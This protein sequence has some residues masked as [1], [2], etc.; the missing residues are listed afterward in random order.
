MNK[1]KKPHIGF[2]FMALAFVLT[3][4]AFSMS[5]VVY[6]IFGY[7]VN[8]WGVFLAVAAFW[9]TGFLL[10]N[11]LFAGERP[12]WVSLLYVG[13]CVALTFA[14]IL[15]IQPC[16]APMGIY[17]TV[18]NMGDVEA[19]AAGVPRAIVTVVLYVVALLCMVVA[20]FCP[21]VSGE[22]EVAQ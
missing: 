5:F 17:F 19:N 14:A 18:G 6:G 8:R 9:L 3:I 20:A 7:A 1:L 13:V 4:V 10:V 11:A 16:L 22:K 21:A 15:F 12:F 2:I